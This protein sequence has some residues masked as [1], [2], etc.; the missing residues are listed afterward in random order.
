MIA[1]IGDVHGKFYELRHEMINLLREHGKLDFV[2]V[3]D[4]GLGFDSPGRDWEQ[5]KLI[6]EVLI[7]ASNSILYVIRGNHDNPA[8]WQ[9]GTGF[10]FSNIQ[11]IEESIIEIDGRLCYFLGGAISIDR[12]KRIQGVSYWTGESTVWNNNFSHYRITSCDL[13]FT[14]DVYQKWTP[15][16]IHSPYALAWAERDRKLIE[17]LEYQQERVFETIS[18]HISYMKPVHWFHG[19]YHESHKTQIEN[20]T[21]TV[22]GLSELEIY[23]V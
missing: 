12:C 18:K 14:H 23:L 2:Q 8:F 22:I 20:P 7:Q 13:I 11:F 9:P 1:V 10:N 6:N 3:G 17:D 5:L 19:H 15:F 16:T 21:V 4:F